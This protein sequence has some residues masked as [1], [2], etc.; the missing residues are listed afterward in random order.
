[1]YPNLD[2]EM[3]RRGLRR[4][5]LAPVFKNRI[6]TVSD[7]LNGKSPILLDEALAVKDKYFPDLSLEFLFY[8]SEQHLS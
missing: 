8:R 2:A 7:K 6:P 4:K 1:M 5:D 3:V